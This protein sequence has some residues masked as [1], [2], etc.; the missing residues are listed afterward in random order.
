MPKNANS[1]TWS[2]PV[3]W[4]G[5]RYSE[6]SDVPTDPST[7]PQYTAFKLFSFDSGNVG[8]AIS[9]TDGLFAPRVITGL[10]QTRSNDIAGPFGGGKVA[11]IQWTQASVDYFGGKICNVGF[12]PD[13]GSS[14]WVRIYHYFPNDFCFQNNGDGDEWGQTKW[15]RFQWTNDVGPRHTF[16]I[17]NWSNSTCNTSGNMWGATRESISTGQNMAFTNK[18]SILRGQWNCLEWSVTFSTNE[19]TGKI[20]A[21]LNGDF[22][23]EVTGV[24]MPDTVVL[25][26]IVF[27]DYING[28]SVVNT[29]YIDEGIITFETPDKLDSGN[30]PMIGTDRK[31]GDF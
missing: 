1:K 2:L 22:V 14:C 29:F 7:L 20:R 9:G 16:Q 4:N 23:G 18:P 13:D 31:V 15:L 8:D 30:R 6:A 3:R 17:G 26:S 5:N 27:G 10:S 28:G 12:R 11:K 24:T 19:N 21:W 25:D